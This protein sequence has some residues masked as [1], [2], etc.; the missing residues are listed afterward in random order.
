MDK[1]E[2]F[3]RSL[4]TVIMR[5]DLLLAGLHQQP[6]YHFLATT[7]LDL[8][9]SVVLFVQTFAL[10]KKQKNEN[11]T[12]RF[13]REYQQTPYKNFSSKGTFRYRYQQQG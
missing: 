1:K 8:D 4:F 6:G 13:L 10:T 11:R 3:N 2:I 12:H 5:Y 7:N 9:T